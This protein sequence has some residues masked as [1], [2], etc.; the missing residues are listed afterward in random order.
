MSVVAAQEEAVGRRMDSHTA[1]HVLNQI[2]DL[3][4]LRRAAPFRAEAYRRA[5]DAVR[6][7]GADDLAPLLRSGGLACVPGIGPSTLR[8]LTELI[9]TGASSLLEQLRAEVPEGLA[10]L[11]KVP[12]LHL[13]ELLRL[14]REL[15]VDSLESLEDAVRA[16]R[17][18]ALRGYGPKTTARLEQRIAI[19]R[20]AQAWRR[21]PQAVREA[22]AARATLARH[23][24]VQDVHLAGALR[25][26]CEVV[27]EIV[28]VATSDADPAQVANSI[29]RTPGVVATRVEAPSTVS[30]RF[31]DGLP[32]RVRCV[33]PDAL[34]TALFEATGSAAHVDQ[35]PP[36][37]PAREE[38]DVYAGFGLPFIHPELREGAGEIEAALA[39]RLPTPITQEDIRGVLHVHTDW[40]DGSASILELAEAAQARG[41]SYIGISDHSQAAFY[42]GGLSPGAV[43]AQ[44]AEIDRLNADLPRGFRVLKGIEVD[45]LADGRLDYDRA[46]L[47]RFDF[48]IASVHSRFAMD[49]ATMTAR[50]LRA[51]DDPH[52][53]VL[54]H[55]TGRLLLRREPY[56]VDI[57]AVLTKAAAVGV[58][59]ELN[60]DPAR[61]D[62]SWRWCLRAKQ[63]GCTVSLGPDAHSVS[64]LDNMALGVALARKAW[65]EPTD[66]ANTRPAAAILRRPGRGRAPA[67]R[68]S[69]VRSR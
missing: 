56:A 68:R 18:A 61:L 7:L 46:L 6:A 17:L 37:A 51:L 33:S 4:T 3:L 1:G 69:R 14:H 64:G 22:E 60:A 5:A 42:A 9:D 2:G 15:G 66:I 36:P 35:L 29:G 21:Y 38:R 50:I 62:L 45:I 39:A 49:R 19:A 54:G 31:A 43:L 24:E 55:P 20:A 28:L 41:W 23:S 13:T 16:G 25:R 65:L 53:T 47:D 30:L 44:H 59:V 52:V 58:A 11:L 27:D 12:G 26:C 32:V 10:E 67:R 34:G 63:L 48:V 8:V 57:E 40:S